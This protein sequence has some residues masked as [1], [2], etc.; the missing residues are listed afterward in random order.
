MREAPKPLEQP[1]TLKERR[2][3]SPGDP[4]QA[5]ICATQACPWV[6]GVQCPKSCD[7]RVETA[8]RQ[9]AQAATLRSENDLAA[10]ARLTLHAHL[11]HRAALF[12]MGT[13]HLTG[14]V[15][16]R[17]IRSNL[18][19]T[20]VQSLSTPGRELRSPALHL[21]N[22]HRAPLLLEWPAL[23][24]IQDALWRANFERA[25]FRN[26]L[27]DGLLAP[28]EGRFTFLALFDLEGA[29]ARCPRAV[30]ELAT[31]PA[32]EAWLA[33][34]EAKNAHALR[35]SK[36]ESE[37]LEHLHLGKTNAEIAKTLTKSAATVKTQLEQLYR[38]T[39]AKNRAQ[40]VAH[41]LS[42]GKIR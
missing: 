9:R 1:L 37:L 31:L 18:A 11:P 16:D 35:L 19:E 42:A 39:G 3:V 15:V 7:H 38:K 26:C 2:R 36:A 23:G 41:S 13:V 34:G 27:V 10:W 20:Y 17:V 24:G 5:L 6:A 8:A 14:L 33:P 40:L 25:G 30:R 28:L 4:A 21:W 22:Q 32:H 12:G 29:L